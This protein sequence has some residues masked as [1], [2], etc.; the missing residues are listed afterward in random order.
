VA[1]PALAAGVLLAL[2]LP[3]FGFWILALPGAGLLAWRLGRLSAGGR[4]LAGWMAGLGLFV[5]GLWWA[6]SFNLYGG[7]VLMAVQALTVA[8]AALIVP[9]GRGRTAALA[10]AMV[11]FEALRS[12]WPFGGLPL[13]GIALGQAGGPLA[14]GARLGGPLL[15]VGLVW[16]AGAGLA[17]VAAAAGPVGAG[18]LGPEGDGAGPPRGRGVGPWRAAVLALAAVVALAT[19]GALAADGGGGRSTL[20]VA[21]VQGGGVRGLRKSEVS[22]ASVFA[23]QLAATRTIAAADGGRPPT[24]VVWPEDVVSLDE[25]LTQSPAEATL[26]AVA[27]RL[28]STLT[29]GV[30]ETVSATAFRNEI[31][32]F[33]PSGRLVARFEK[34]HRVPFGEYIPD[35]AFFSHLANLSAVPLDAIAGHGD[36]VL[37]TPAAA[38]G[39]MVSYEV[40]FAARGRIATRAGARLLIVPTNTA[41]YSTSQVPTQEIAAS[42]LQA[43]A[44]GRDL[45]QASPTGFSAIIDHDGTVLARTALG[46]RQ[47]LVGD[48]RLRTGRTLYERFGDLPV[49]LGAGALLLGGWGAALTGGQRRRTARRP[50]QDRIAA[51]QRNSGSDV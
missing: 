28:R 27:R 12:A 21:A 44:E 34:V 25:L 7:I 31:V 46:P 29:V 40:F 17:G 18:S 1:L 3:P 23:A 9:A 47:V 26:A 11:L 19:W 32:A 2:S 10:G 24:L 38:L 39:T 13:G 49:L 51:R 33:A 43:I 6:L 5:P 4:L 50:G 20:R 41:S 30:T 36:G 8:L 35:R 22:P 15:L 48:V 14:D 42:R 37:D 45:I 16:L